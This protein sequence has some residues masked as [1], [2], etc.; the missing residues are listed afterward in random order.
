M[1]PALSLEELMP[2]QEHLQE[3]VAD[4]EK[5]R[6]CCLLKQEAQAGLCAAM[7]KL[8]PEYHSG[9]THQLPISSVQ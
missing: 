7:D 6:D 8:P 2:V 3:L 1:E 9:V 4:C 5:D